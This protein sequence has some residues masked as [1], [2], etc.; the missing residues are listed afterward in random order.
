M[1]LSL[2]KQVSDFRRKLRVFVENFFIL[3]PS[4]KV[5]A[6]QNLIALWTAPR[7]TN[8]V[9]DRALTEGG[10]ALVPAENLVLIC[11]DGEEYAEQLAKLFLFPQI[12]EAGKFTDFIKYVR[13]FKREIGS[14]SAVLIVG[15]DI[16]DGK[17]GDRT[18]VLRWNLAR[19]LASKSVAT[20][21]FSMSWNAQ[22]TPAALIAAKAASKAGVK[23]FA[24]DEI[25]LGRLR[26]DGLIAEFASDVSFLRRD[27]VE[28][29]SVVVAHFAKSTKKV[30]V[31]VS[32]W[33]T[34]N[35]EMFEGLVESLKSL[36]SDYELIYIPM[37]HYGANTDTAAC[38]KLSNSVPGWILPKLP[39]PAELRWM[40]ARSEFSIS[41]RMHCCL[42]GFAVG[43]P[44]I[45]LEYQGKFKGAFQTFGMERLAILPEEFATTFPAAF[46]EVRSSSGELRA[47]ITSK[48]AEIA[49]SSQ[50]PIDYA[51][52]TMNLAD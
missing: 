44:S 12:A 28:P 46:A 19:W 42:I 43:L 20:S 36:P 32:D 47:L 41:A 6:N 10:M 35:H 18:S 14:C 45:G 31:N 25:S 24:R 4:G 1:I 21:L 51:K 38:E 8:N 33:V 23:I 16:M 34:D 26:N 17:Y 30:L 2:K 27:Q 39:T 15:A 29:D 52:S 49:I 40:A 7:I 50:A 13:K 9:G 5:K 11:R 37:V 22:P 48:I 3:L